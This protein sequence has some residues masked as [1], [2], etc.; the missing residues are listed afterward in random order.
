MNSL[1][2]INEVH[3]LILLYGSEVVLEH[4][5]VHKPHCLGEYKLDVIV[6]QSEDSK[7]TM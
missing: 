6:L 3:V 4:S 7:L 5:V 1:D 2:V